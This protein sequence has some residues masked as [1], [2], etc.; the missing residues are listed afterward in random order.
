VTV[1]PEIVAAREAVKKARALLEAAVNHSAKRVGNR[2]LVQEMKRR[3]RDVEDAL[4]NFFEVVTAQIDA[5][6]QKAGA[7]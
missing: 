4:E 6:A 3:E 2:A 7:A 5:D 1:T